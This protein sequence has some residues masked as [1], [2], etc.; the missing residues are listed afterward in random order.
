MKRG[1]LDQ[2]TIVD[3]VLEL[4]SREPQARITFKRLGEALGVDATAMYRHFRN[5][6]ELT[7]AALD[8]LAETATADA[9]ASTGDWRDRIERFATRMAE[10]S[11]EH[12][13]IGAEGAVLDP[14]GPGDVASDEFILEMLTSAGLSGAGLIRAYAA[15]SGFTL[16]QSAALAQEALVRRDIA[17][18]GSIPWISTFGSVDLAGFPH[19]REHRDQLLAIDGLTVYRAGITA[20]LDSISRSAAAA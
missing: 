8:R 18:D 1:R 11:L 13:A 2:R 5:K 17:R 9:R 7:R 4:A 20:I 6:D 12:P 10:L 19:V 14:V 16:A 3:A 15:I